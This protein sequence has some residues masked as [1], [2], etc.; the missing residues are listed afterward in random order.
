[1]FA[2][3]ATW[4]RSSRV[5]PR[6]AGGNL[7]QRSVIVG[8]GPSFASADF[9]AGRLAAVELEPRG[10]ALKWRPFA[11][12]AERNTRVRSPGPDVNIT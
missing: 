4:S 3:S 9:G 8:V 6:G 2:M 11:C 1:M 10:P 7:P 12:I 5:P